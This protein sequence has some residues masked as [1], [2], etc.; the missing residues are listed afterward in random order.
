MA[1]HDYYNSRNYGYD[2]HQDSPYHDVSN[3]RL[4]APLPSLPGESNYPSNT[5]ENYASPSVPGESNYHSNTH[6]NYASPFNTPFDDSYNSYNPSRQS[7]DVYPQQTR[8]HD[9]FTDNNAI[10]LQSQPYNKYNKSDKPESPIAAE[11][12]R[13]PPYD[14]SQTQDRVRGW[15]RGKIPWAVYTL[16]LIQIIVFIVEIAKNGWSE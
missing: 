11:G 16:S 6:E 14:Q 3:Q 9:P 15:F 1:S 5:H 13:Y 10:P 8:S 2:S 7:L 4:D 12:Q